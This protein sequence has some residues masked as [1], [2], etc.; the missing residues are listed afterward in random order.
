MLQTRDALTDILGTVAD[1]G[2]R[3]LLMKLSPNLPPLA[4]DDALAVARE[5]EL[6]GIVTTNTTTDQHRCNHRPVPRLV[7]CRASHSRNTP[8]RWYAMSPSTLICR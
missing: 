1:A 3:P 6:D 8:R 2:A 5:L 4:V 7:D